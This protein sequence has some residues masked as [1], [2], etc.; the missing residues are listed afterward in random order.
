M[1]IIQQRLAE[2]WMINKQREL[3]EAEGTEMADCMKVNC[4]YVQKMGEL[5][6]LSYLAYS[7]QDW[8]WLHEV[9]ARI[10]AVEAK[11]QVKNPYLPKTL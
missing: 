11:Y 3:T 7:T 5:D 4:D 9:C 6:N 1:L 2:L 8:E 10:E